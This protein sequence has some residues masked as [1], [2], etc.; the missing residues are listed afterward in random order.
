[1][2]GGFLVLVPAMPTPRKPSPRRHGTK[3]DRKL[4]LQLAAGNAY[5]DDNKGVLARAENYLG[6]IV[7]GPVQTKAKRKK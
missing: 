4:A 5:Y 2:A 6:F 3:A 7:R 1:M